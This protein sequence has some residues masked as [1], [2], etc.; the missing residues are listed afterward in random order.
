MT[1][2]TNAVHFSADRKLLDFI[3][4]R[5]EKLEQFFDRIVSADV[6]LRLENSGKIKE[7]VTE[8]KLNIPG[9][10]LFVKENN[11]SFEAA[12]DSA[13]DALKRQ[14]IKYKERMRSK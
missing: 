8:I 11:K 4:T 14:L 3:K 10:T 2:Q 6:V 13:I 5:L 7:K 9:T 1:I 12:V